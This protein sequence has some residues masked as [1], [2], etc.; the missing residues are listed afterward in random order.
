MIISNRQIMELFL[1]KNSYLMDKDRMNLFFSLIDENKSDILFDIGRE[2]AV[3]MKDIDTNI[4]FKNIMINKSHFFIISDNK[5]KIVIDYNNNEPMSKYFQNYNEKLLPELA[6]ISFDIE[7]YSINSRNDEFTIKSIKSPSMY[8]KIPNSDIS[9]LKRIIKKTAI[10]IDT[11]KIFEV[12]DK[13]TLTGLGIGEKRISIYFEKTFN[14]YLL[15]AKTFVEIKERCEK[16]GFHL[17]E[18]DKY[19]LGLIRDTFNILKN[20]KITIFFK[21]NFPNS[22]DSDAKSLELYIE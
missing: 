16:R 10:N 11:K 20:R 12:T 1:N 13:L 15:A 2:R 14:S 18:S 6:Q 4:I 21:F 19:V 7:D 5:I 8:F 3:H 17:N 9:I 22:E